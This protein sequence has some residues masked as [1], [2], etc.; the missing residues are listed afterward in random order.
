MREGVFREGGQHKIVRTGSNEYTMSIQIPTDA[1]GLIGRECPD[2]SCS[3]GY[4]KVKLGTG[5]TEGQ[6]EAFCPYCRHAGEPSAFMTKAQIEYAK[7]TVHREAAKGLSSMIENALQLGPTGKKRF[8]GDF[9]SVEMSYKPGDLPHVKPPIEEKLRRDVTCPNC[10]LEHAVFGLAIWC[11]DCGNDI[12][13][14]HVDKEFSVVRQMLEDVS[15]RQE[16]LGT[17]VA[18]RDVENALEDMVSIFEA[19]L[20]AMTRRRM[21][22]SGISDEDIEDA[23]RKRVGNKYQSIPLATKVCEHEFGIGLFEDFDR[24]EV[25]TLRLTFEK[26]HPI[27]HNLGIVDRKYL[28]KV[29]SGELEG[30]DIPVTVEEIN[31]A[32]AFSIQVLQKL[33]PRLF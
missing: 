1:D 13:L 25:E 33:H 3:P 30:R 29:R 28:E 21:K 23:L 26:R 8:G 2:S 27:T 18:A 16:Q 14:V 17:Q 24:R 7:N 10:G 31:G 11:P 4:F 15:R 19:A 12:F 6:L 20:R 5:I 9:I 22:N 32:I